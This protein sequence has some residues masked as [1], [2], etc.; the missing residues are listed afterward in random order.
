LNVP[1]YY[2]QKFP[3][4][5]KGTPAGGPG[6][7]YGLCASV[8]FKQRASIMES[9]RNWQES[10]MKRYL[11][12]YSSHFLG[13]EWDVTR[14]WGRRAGIVLENKRLK[15]GCFF[16]FNRRFWDCFMGRVRKI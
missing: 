13:V 16:S 4:S 9:G 10:M 3:I 11:I 15:K 12:P 8:F 1:D 2:I 6:P 7:F 14:F 5:R